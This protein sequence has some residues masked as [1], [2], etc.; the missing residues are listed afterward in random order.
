[1]KAISN[2]LLG[3]A[4]YSEE[5][6]IPLNDEIVWGMARLPQHR[7]GLPMDIWVNDGRFDR[8]KGDAL[9]FHCNYKNPNDERYVARFLIREGLPCSGCDD[10]EKDVEVLSRWVRQNKEVLIALANQE[11][12]QEDFLSRKS[13]QDFLEE[14]QRS[15]AIRTEMAKEL[16]V[17]KTSLPWVLWAD[18]DKSN[19]EIL[20][21]F[22][23][24][25]QKAGTSQKGKVEILFKMGKGVWDIC[26]VVTR[27]TAWAFTDAEEALLRKWIG[28][29]SL[30]LLKLKIFNVDTN[31]WA[32]R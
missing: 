14:V 16:G 6:A 7:T 32:L 9:F 1:M 18:D 17:S 3:G 22:I 28:Q 21:L 25:P 2:F 15:G 13:V 5:P 24:P 8:S 10:I 23:L 19:L 11:I 31:N 30:D 29:H 26:V 20:T 12:E 27:P 4:G